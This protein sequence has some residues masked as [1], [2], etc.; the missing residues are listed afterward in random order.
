MYQSSW[1]RPKIR[2]IGRLIFST[3]LVL[4]M[5]KFSELSAQ[6]PFTFEDGEP[7]I[8]QEVNENFG[9]LENRING[10]IRNIL[11]HNSRITSLE[12]ANAERD[13]VGFDLQSVNRQLGSLN[14]EINNLKRKISNS[15][16]G[17]TNT[18]SSDDSSQESDQF[19]NF[20]YSYKVDENIRKSKWMVA[21]FDGNKIYEIEYPAGLNNLTSRGHLQYYNN[22]PELYTIG[23]NKHEGEIVSNTNIAGYPAEISLLESIIHAADG[24][25]T[26]HPTAISYQFNAGVK[27]WLNNDSVIQFYIISPN[28]FPQ[29]SP[30]SDDIWRCVETNYQSD[31]YVQSQIGKKGKP[32]FITPPSAS[33][34]EFSSSE[35]RNCLTLLP[36]QDSREWL[37]S[38]VLDILNHISIREV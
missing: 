35:L 14:T 28:F 5:G 6:I 9:Y 11:L 37:Q 3:C 33:V 38:H 32:I 19:Y 22:N 25:I 34:I 12:T 4:T 20:V 1:V 23:V 7:A 13:S 8:A 21:T 27:V 30:H 18:N 36:D 17:T 24:K 31:S 16:N 26:P 10:T 29:V 2:T 15:S